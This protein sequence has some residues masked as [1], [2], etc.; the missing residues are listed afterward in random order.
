MWVLEHVRELGMIALFVILALAVSRARRKGP[1][2]GEAS[3]AAKASPTVAR[4]LPPA[5]GEYPCLA[6]EGPRACY[7]SP[8]VVEVRSWIEFDWLDALMLRLGFHRRVEHAVQVDYGSDEGSVYCLRCAAVA[9][10]ECERQVQAFR[11]GRADASVAEARRLA[12]FN[13]FGLR[14]LVEDATRAQRDKFAEREA[15]RSA[16]SAGPRAREDGA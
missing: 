1:D 10:A 8:H 15:R 12:E 4:P 9:R 7:R 11:A 14:E 2:E 16:A 5:A 3:A 13:A 6:C